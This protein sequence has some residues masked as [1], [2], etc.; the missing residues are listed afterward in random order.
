MKPDD[1]NRPKRVSEELDAQFDFTNLTDENKTSMVSKIF[2]SVAP[3]YDLMN[4]LMSLGIHRIW[5]RELIRNINLVPGLKIV[6]VGGGTGDISLGIMK[7]IACHVT[8]CDINEKMLSVGRNRAINRGHLNGP[9][10]ICGDSASLPI[11]ECYADVYVSAFCLRNVTNLEKSLKEARRI[12][13][14]GGHFLCLEFSKIDTQVFEYLYDLYS[15]QIIPFLG[16]VVAGDRAAYQYL[17]ESIR[18]FPTKS[19]FAEM[20]LDADLNQVSFRKLSGGIA[21]IHSAWRL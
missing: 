3:R 13:K 18:R 21:T 12:L 8:V 1:L 9:D 20:I 14:P 4:D 15:Y 11:P 16:K 10:W 19:A 17:V 7:K 5:K 2:S 6:D